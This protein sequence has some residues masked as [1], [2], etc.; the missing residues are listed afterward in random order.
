M[1][2]GIM[3]IFLKMNKY[4]IIIIGLIL[5]FIFSRI[6]S[7]NP[8]KEL[9]GDHGDKYEFFNFMYLV[10]ENLRSGKYALE[11]TDILR[12]P[13]GFELSHG[14]DGVLSTFSGALLSFILPLP[15]AYNLV[16][17]LILFLNFYITYSFF[18]TISESGL[19]GLFAGIFYGFSPYVIARIN[20]H[21][22]LAF[23]GGFPFL[24]KA[25]Y[26]FFR[27]KGKAGFIAYFNI[28]FGIL[29]IAFGSLQYLIIVFWF[30]LFLLTGYLLLYPKDSL[31]VII[32]Y[33]QMAKV[34]VRNKPEVFYFVLLLNAIIALYFFG[35]FA[36][37]IIF[38]SFVYPFNYGRYVQCCLPQLSDILIP[39]QYIN[40]LYSKL[41]FS[42]ASIEKVISPGLVGWIIFI[43]FYFKEKI[44]RR[45]I[46]ILLSLAVYL[47]ATLGMI[48]LPY[49]PEGG[50]SIVI[51]SILI[52]VFMSVIPFFKLKKFIYPLILLMLLE[53]L[54]FTVHRTFALPFMESKVAAQLPEKAI[55]NI[56]LSA[57]NAF[58]SVLPYMTH[59]KIVD[60]YFHDTAENKSTLSF[61]EQEY[62]QRYICDSEKVHKDK[63]LY[64]DKN[65]ND[66]L[67]LLRNF[68]IRSIIIHKNRQYEK[69]Y[70]DECSNVRYWWY[71]LNPE[72]IVLKTDTH[73][74]VSSSIKLIKYPSLKTGFYFHKDGEFILDGIH[75]AP[76]IF[77]DANI[78]VNNSLYGLKW[79]SV[80]E[81]INTVFEAPMVLQVNAGEEL[82][83][84]SDMKFDD[85]IYINFYYS[86]EAD[87]NSHEVKKPIERVYLS[88]DYEI[89][90]VN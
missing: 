63:L 22:N 64:V 16:I 68:D 49:W 12:Y 39:N 15:L 81:G 46:F 52:L 1:A 6:Y 89:F 26:D 4:K 55:L 37:G 56:P 77:T 18:S 57:T 78:K 24:A 30:F 51:F 25:F 79:N 11:K 14:Y 28:I 40:L 80:N 8:Y 53:R 27:N 54:T 48:P 69:F 2:V 50:R 23:I 20:S 5:A 33:L 61:F 31:A 35:G 76:G 72:V 74:V 45:K 85:T 34:K 86:F 66:T 73:G 38:G 65:F 75:I 13:N 62:T 67:A 3:N 10:G 17:I 47:I 42:S 82:I 21:P 83:L 32:Y 29:L 19:F 59:K 41:N 58:R 70:Y 36:K 87:E 9:L 7:I 43:I 88:S 84:S 71:N 60:G 90:R 44:N